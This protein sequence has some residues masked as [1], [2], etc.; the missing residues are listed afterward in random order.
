MSG[1]AI[2]IG[3]CRVLVGACS[4]AGR[5]LTQES[6]WYPKR[7]M[8][9]ADRLAYY[10]SQ[11]PI[12]EIESTYWFPPTPEVARQWVER[13]PDGFTMDVR[14]WSLFSGQPTLPPS[15]W[16]D[17]QSEVR[18]E[19]RDNT[20]L[21]MAHLSADAVTEAWARFDHALRPLH[22]AGRLGAVLLQYPHWFS[23]KEATRAEL[24]AA[25]AAIPDYRVSV[26]F[27]SE[28]WVEPD[29]LDA[30]IALFEEHDM[31]LVAV[32]APALTPVI[33][34]TGDVAI[35]RLHGRDHP[36]WGPR[37]HRPTWR[38]PYRYG[39]DELAEWVPRVVELAGSVSELHVLFNN[40]HRDDAVV[41]ATELI[42][43]LTAI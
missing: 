10:A 31:I 13:T 6:D 2:V 15:L 22:D 4:W 40:C 30:T 39:P 26:E 12:V 43:L 29:E 11:F 14:A 3:N 37:P 9:A 41:N 25:R 5:S 8:K 38:T 21:Y 1:D 18:P 35:A 27:A 19:T 23:P 20:N 33:A 17:L 16:P 34:A 42:D 24:L 28:R 32:D 36:P 7:T